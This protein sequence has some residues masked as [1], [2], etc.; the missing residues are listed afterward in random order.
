MRLA[1]MVVRPAVLL[2]VPAYMLWLGNPPLPAAIWLALA[3]T[4]LAIDPRGR[5]RFLAGIILATVI[6]GLIS[7]V[8]SIQDPTAR[9][10]LG[11]AMQTAQLHL[12][13][14]VAVPLGFYSLAA[15]LAAGMV[16]GTADASWRR[17]LYTVFGVAVGF[18]GFLYAMLVL[19]PDPWGPGRHVLLPPPLGVPDE[20][21]EE[22]PPVDLA[23]VA[24]VPPRPAASPF[25][26][27]KGLAYGPHGYRNTLDLFRPSEAQGR[28]PVVVYLHGGGTMDGGTGLGSDGGLPDVW[29]DALLTRGLAIAEINYRLIMADPRSRHVEVTGPFPA[30]IQDC[31]AAV[32]YLR[33]EAGVLGIDPGRIG[34]MGHSFGG[35]LAAL[36]GLAWDRPEFLT[37]D[38]RGISSRVDAVVDAAGISDFRI[39]GPQMRY[40]LKLWNLPSADYGQDAYIA[41][42]YCRSES[43]F[44]AASPITHVR[45]DAAPFLI[46]FGF[47]D[48][49]IQGEM[50]HMRLKSAGVSS[51][52]VIIPGAGHS[53][54][55]YPGTGEFAA[56]FL[57]DKLDK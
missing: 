22:R 19:W 11:E 52:L 37:D 5:G 3:W 38:R 48:L 40:H 15:A 35:S 16:R 10:L 7:G 45:R 32:R 27:R 1:G 56:A 25:E 30:Q 14:K 43:E 33:A 23:E 50:L 42:P 54:A 36:A 8:Q 21:L 41:T 18:G 12:F 6:A 13:R 47:R 55:N 51:R 20:F 4:A 46:L 28:P 53:L 17:C 24:E 31:L 26:V 39:W 9:K 34:V 29:R 44:A 2:A 57:R 49:A